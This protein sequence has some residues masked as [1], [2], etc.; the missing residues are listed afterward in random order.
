MAIEYVE[1]IHESSPQHLRRGTPIMKEDKQ[2]RVNMEKS[3]V[4][5]G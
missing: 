3:K 2:K 1:L 5:T 4:D